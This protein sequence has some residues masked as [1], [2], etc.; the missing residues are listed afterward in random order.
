[1]ST[2][3]QAILK[4]TDI[5]PQKIQAHVLE[6]QQELQDHLRQTIEIRL[7]QCLSSEQTSYEELNLELPEAYKRKLDDDLLQKIFSFFEKVKKAKTLRLPNLNKIDNLIRMI[8]FKKLN[9]SGDYERIVVPFS[10]T[11]QRCY[12]LTILLINNCS[13]IQEIYF[14][15][16]NS[17]NQD[18]KLVQDLV[19]KIEKNVVIKIDLPASQK[20]GETIHKTIDQTVFTFD[21]YYQGPQPEDRYSMFTAYDYWDINH[22]HEKEITGEDITVAVVDS[23]L[24]CSHP[25][26]HLK[27]NTKFKDCTGSCLGTNDTDGHGTMCAGIICGDSFEYSETPDSYT[28][29]DKLET[30]PPG[31]AHKAKLVVYKVYSKNNASTEVICAALKDI[32]K[33]GDVDVVSLSLG[34]LAF[35]FSI[36][37]AVSNL[38]S[39][40]VIVVCAASNYGNK[41][42]QPIVFPARLG[43]VLSIGSHDEHGKTSRFSPVGQQIDFLAPG[44]EITAPSST[45]Y[46]HYIEKN[47]GTSF[48]APAV[49]GLICLILSYIKKHYPDILHHFKCHWVMKELLREISTSP[50]RPTDDQGFGALNP[51]RFFEQPK[52]FLEYI[53]L[54]VVHEQWEYSSPTPTLSQW[55]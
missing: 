9:I 1:M 45:H 14:Q 47:S 20:S 10:I 5:L 42:I 34:S 17:E 12:D 16:S 29:G 50:G 44:E 11:Q 51:M 54:K 43:N 30:F 27:E 36:A 28:E 40:G 46:N 4:L 13:S 31:I 26:F 2:N 21:R 8:E 49:A 25:A 32:K 22:I 7:E 38:V 6:I 33:R 18:K 23:G 39:K 35:T 41:Y 24:D 19:S 52:R 15:S 55:I 3:E 53:M 37:K 48:A